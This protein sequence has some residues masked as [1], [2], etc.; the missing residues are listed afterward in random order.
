MKF[1]ILISTMALGI[2]FLGC[3]PNPKNKADATPMPK[4]ASVTL[5]G[6]ESVNDARLGPVASISVAIKTV[7]TMKKVPKLIA[8][9]ITDQKGEAYRFFDFPD[10]KGGTRRTAIYVRGLEA[11]DYAASSNVTF[12]VLF[13]IEQIPTNAGS[14]FLAGEVDVGMP[15]PES[16]RI[17][18]R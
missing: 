18:V 5:Q 10:G 1:F 16:F 17:Q 12:N 2:S 7:R 6:V 13:P 4:M 3:R 9:T 14:V 11:P 15:K 8:W